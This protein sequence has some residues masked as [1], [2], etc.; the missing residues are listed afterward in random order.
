LKFCKK[1]KKKKK[2]SLLGSADQKKVLLPE[3]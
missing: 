3:K 2:I 1:K